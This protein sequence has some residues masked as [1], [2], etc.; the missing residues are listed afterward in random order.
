MWTE[1][2]IIHVTEKEIGQECTGSPLL[3]VLAVRV[4]AEKIRSDTISKGIK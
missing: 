4:T 2:R 1:T 3:F